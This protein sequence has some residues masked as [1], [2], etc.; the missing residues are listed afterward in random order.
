MP[1]MWWPGGLG[2]C[3]QALVDETK[4][5]RSE[6][7]IEGESS[8]EAFARHEGKTDCIHQGQ[9]MQIGGFDN[10]PSGFQVSTSALEH[11]NARQVRHGILPGNRHVLRRVAIQERE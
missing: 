5:C 8:T 6:V 4:T 2:S 7:M 9:L 11:I 1:K 3:G 10:R